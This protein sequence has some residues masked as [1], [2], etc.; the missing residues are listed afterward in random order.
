MYYVYILVS[1]VDPDKHYVGL[2]QNLEV[3]IDTHNSGQSVYTNKFKPW[4]IKNYI[5]FTDKDAAVVFEKYL[6]TGSG[7]AFLKKYLL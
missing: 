3:R 1:S 6:K 7:H 2:T 5:A 4:K